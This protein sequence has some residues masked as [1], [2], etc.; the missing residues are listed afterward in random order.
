MVYVTTD[1]L[2]KTAAKFY[3]FAKC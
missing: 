1:V 3:R 2:F